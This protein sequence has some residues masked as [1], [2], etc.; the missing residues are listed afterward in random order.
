MQYRTLGRTGLQVSEIGVGGAQFGLANYM[1]R[2][3]P[4]LTTHQHRDIIPCC[5]VQE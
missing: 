2:W 4:F 1:G 3:D 5:K